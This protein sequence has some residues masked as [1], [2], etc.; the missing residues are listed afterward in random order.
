M[1]YSDVSGVYGLGVIWHESSDEEDVG[2]GTGRL[3]L[4]S[5]GSFTYSGIE[6]KSEDDLV[7]TPSMSGDY[8]LNSNQISLIVREAG[9][10]A[11]TNADLGYTGYVN[12]NGNILLSIKWDSISSQDPDDEELLVYGFKLD[13]TP[14][15]NASIAGTYGISTVAYT[16][17]GEV[18]SENGRMTLASDGQFSYRG[19]QN[20][21][22]NDLVNVTTMS[23][24]YILRDNEVRSVIDTAD[25]QSL[26]NLG[27]NDFGYSG[28]VDDDGRLLIGFEWENYTLQDPADDA[29]LGVGFK[30]EG[31]P[32][33]AD[34]AGVYGLGSISY[35]DWDEQ[36]TSEIGQITLQSDGTFSV[37][38][39]ENGSADDA[40]LTYTASGIFT[41]QNHELVLTT[42]VYNGQSLAERG[43]N[44]HTVTGFI[45]NDGMFT[46]GLEWENYGS[47]DLDDAETLLIG[48][49]IDESSDPSGPSDSTQTNTV[50]DSEAQDT[51]SS[52]NSTDSTSSPNNDSDSDSASSIASTSGNDRLSALAN[53]GLI[54]GGEG[55]DTV[56]F[57]SSST[58]PVKTSAGWSVNGNTLVNVE[59]IQFSN[60]SIALDMGANENGGKTALFIGALAPTLVQDPGSF[61]TILH[62]VDNNFNDL[63]ALSQ[64]AIDVGLISGLAGSSSNEAL[65]NL[66][67]T[68]ILGSPN[69]LIST[70][71]VGYMNGAIANY[72]QAQFLAAVATTEANQVNVDLAG[73]SQTGAEFISL[74]L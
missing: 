51:T 56:I 40:I 28:Y 44:D 59:R 62:F 16:G 74:G 18:I 46:L 31:S 39:S 33:T 8:S 43:S 50:S 66:V 65:A 67:T 32:T 19:I 22:A 34:V 24:T 71:L 1:N 63:V 4:N 11:I 57:N 6:N 2:S 64:L 68:N 35:T 15:N 26:L 20:S 10:Q 58:S 60:K 47:Q 73:L 61:G 14:N 27:Y 25:G 17:E 54:D 52:N 55:L 49:R 21:N 23:G 48:I 30:L 53:M 37:S 29:A 70:M 72:S 9:G 36:I 13:G 42:Q 41:I 3:I 45:T 69:A 5:D 7:S 38:S 12:S